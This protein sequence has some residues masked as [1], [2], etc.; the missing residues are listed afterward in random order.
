MKTYIIFSLKVC[1]SI[2][3]MG[4]YLTT[5][6]SCS[7]H[8]DGETTISRSQIYLIPLPKSISYGTQNVALPE[9]MTVSQSLTG[10]PSELLKET[11]TSILSN[12]NVTEAENDKAFIRISINQ[13]LEEEGYRI[14]ITETGVNIEYS[15]DKG[16]LWGIQ[17]LRQILLQNNQLSIPM[18]SI[19]DTP[20]KAWRGF[21]I[22]VARHMF[23]MDFLKKITNCLSFYKINKLQIHLT[24]DQGWR[25]EIKKYPELATQ[26]GWR[27]FDEYDNSCNELAKS[28][29]DYTID[30]RFIR[31]NNEYGGYYTQEEMASLI[32][33]ATERGIEVIPEIDMPGHFSSAIKVYPELSCT[34]A[35][36]WGEEFSYP[37][38]AGKT[39]NYS[40]FQDI[41]DEMIALFPGNYVHIG[42]DEVEKDNWKTCE[43]CQQLIA[44][45]NLASLDELQNYFLKQMADHAKNQGKKVMAWDDAF[46]TTNPQDML[47]TYWR[48]WMDEQPGMITQ[49][50]YPIVFMEWGRFYL[51]ADPSDALLKSLYEFT[52]EPQFSGIVESNVVGF[53]ACVWTEMIPNETKFGQHVFPSLQAFSEVAWGSDRDWSSFTN[54]LPWHLNWINQNGIHARQ[55]DFIQ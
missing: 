5:T 33:Y 31:N 17:T 16:L 32:D 12:G 18:L 8:E 25:I 41:L 28:D 40:F 48:D 55:P 26:G 3:L 43:R 53:Q 46:S 38:C 7:D 23:T 35:A 36:G 4:M 20:G 45:E 37:V 15:N 30:T 9:Q 14:D 34:G 6:C 24:D 50:G 47:Y 29:T 27:E 39:E 2:C 19:A 10:I 54:R 11:L 13:T 49:S 42:G 52:F 1:L 51:S 21:H 22:D 44:D